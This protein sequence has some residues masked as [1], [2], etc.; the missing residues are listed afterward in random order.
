MYIK[1]VAVCVPPILQVLFKIKVLIMNTVND[2]IK[3]DILL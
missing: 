3:Y 2:K 1:C